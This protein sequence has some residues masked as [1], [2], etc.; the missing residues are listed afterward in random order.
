MKRKRTR[1]GKS[2]PSPERQVDFGTRDWFTIDSVVHELSCLDETLVRRL[3]ASGDIRSVMR[4]PGRDR[5]PEPMVSRSEIERVLGAVRLP[6]PQGHP[7]L[8]AVVFAG[9]EGT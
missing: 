7:S 3:V 4:R 2:R 9:P 1:N 8:N 5:Q 6:P